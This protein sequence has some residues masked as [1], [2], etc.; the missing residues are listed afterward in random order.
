ML[1]ATDK[2]YDDQVFIKQQSTETVKDHLPRTH[3]W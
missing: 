3:D 1:T 2:N